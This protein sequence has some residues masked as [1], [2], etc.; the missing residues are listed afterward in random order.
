LYLTD[1]DVL[2][3]DHFIPK[4]LGGK[5]TVNNLQI[6]HRHCRDRKI[7]KA[8]LPIEQGGWYS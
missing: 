1:V 3:L 5:D 8:R 6:L 4:R 7:A 2:E